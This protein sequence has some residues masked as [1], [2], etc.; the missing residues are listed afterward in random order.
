M[1]TISKKV[2]SSLGRGKMDHHVVDDFLVGEDISYIYLLLEKSETFWKGSSAPRMIVTKV[3]WKSRTISCGKKGSGWLSILVMEMLAKLI[4]SSSLW[5]V[6]LGW[7]ASALS[8]I[9]EVPRNLVNGVLVHLSTSETFA[10]E[11][12]C[13]GRARV[14]VQCHKKAVQSLVADGV[15]HSAG[16]VKV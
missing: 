9:K 4:A 11:W 2:S 5:K 14:R 15:P 12:R 6:R 3:R 8:C 1:K 16:K 7:V 10:C 13:L